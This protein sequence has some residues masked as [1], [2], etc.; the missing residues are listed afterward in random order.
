MAILRPQY[1]DASAFCAHVDEVLRP[2]GYRLIGAFTE[3]EERAAAVAGFRASHS[4]GWGH[5]LY[6]DDLCT[7]P[8]ARRRGLAGML[9]EWL[10]GEARRLGCG[11]LHLDSGV[12]AERFDAHRFYHAQGFVISSHHFARRL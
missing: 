10:A 4:L 8:D 7:A 12:G 6:V 2:V 1:D 9:L 5:H 3:D 11:Q